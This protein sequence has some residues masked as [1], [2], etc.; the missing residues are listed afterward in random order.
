MLPTDLELLR[1][2]AEGSLDP[3]GRVIGSYG[4]TMVC[5]DRDQALFIGAEVPDAVATELVSTFDR[6]PRSTPPGE[7]PALELCRQLLHRPVQCTAGLSYLI[8]ER[9]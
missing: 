4:V 8:D 2:Q 1:I 5:S 6:A 9:T 7:P 3:V